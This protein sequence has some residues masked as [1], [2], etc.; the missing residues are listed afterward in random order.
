MFPKTETRFVYGNYSYVEDIEKETDV[1]K[2]YH[3]VYKD[4]NFLKL[5]DFSPYER[6]TEKAF[7]WFV[8]N[9]LPTRDKF[10]SSSPIR[11]RDL[12]ME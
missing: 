5:L 4:G 12:G 7:R 2:I 6:M 11:L 10:N 8:D 9:N 1:T 3:L